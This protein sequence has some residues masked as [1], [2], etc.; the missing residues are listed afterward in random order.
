[1]KIFATLRKYPRFKNAKL[2]M[3]WKP[4]TPEM[5][6]Y[7]ASSGLANEIVERVEVSNEQ[8]QALYSG[9]I[10]LLFPS[11]EEGFGWP[12]LEAQA[13]GC[14]VITSNRAPMTEIAGETALFIDPEVPESAAEMIADHVSDLPALRI[15]GFKNL[16][17][18]T[19][20]GMIH[21]YIKYYEEV[22]NKENPTALSNP[23]ASN[24]SAGK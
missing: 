21:A 17:R 5:R 3:A 14:P 19:K 2:I 18:F 9:A 6:R 11:L 10:A 24:P 13:C 8:L 12:V 15:A 22:V 7:A 1:M 16:A 23:A 20:D 4:W